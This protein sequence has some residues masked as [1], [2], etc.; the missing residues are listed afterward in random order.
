MSSHVAG[1]QQYQ[2]P[3][4]SEAYLVEDELNP[5]MVFAEPETEPVLLGAPKLGPRWD[6]HHQK[7]VTAYRAM[8]AP[9]GFA[10]MLAQEDPNIE[11]RVFLLDNSGSTSQSDGHVLEKNHCGQLQAVPASRWDEICSMALAHAEWNARAGVRSE[12]L[13]LNPPCPN[14]P[15][16][17]RDFVIIDPKAGSS[18]AQVEVLAQVLRSNGPRGVT[19][20]ASRLQ[21]LRHRLQGQVKAGRRIMLTIVTD[22]MPTSPDCGSCTQRDRDLFVKELRAFTATFNSFVVIRLATDEESTMEYYNK[23]D[24]ELEL[25]LD[26]LDDLRGEAQEVY[27]CGNG[28]FAYTP[29]MHRIREGGT[30]EKLFDLLDERALKLPEIAKFLEFLFRTPQSAPFPRNPEELYRIAKEAVE[31]APLVYNGRLDRMSPAVDLRLLKKSLGLNAAARM[32]SLPGRMVRAM[33]CSKHLPH[34]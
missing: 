13:L 15:V 7:R 23:I 19:P 16:D 3:T 24:E 5:T 11:L 10:N 12:F 27:D 31:A 9:W 26:I 33:T 17:G 8:D 30:L 34:D 32:R 1:L 28:W 14:E 2:M 6:V 25:P 21:Q 4:A 29:L 18:Q 22:G 20:L